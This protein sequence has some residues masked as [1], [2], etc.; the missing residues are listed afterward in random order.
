MYAVCLVVLER[1]NLVD[2][3]DP[4]FHYLT[5]LVEAQG[6]PNGQTHT[7]QLENRWNQFLDHLFFYDQVSYGYLKPKLP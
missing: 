7:L 6:Y 5:Y 2:M 4:T 1:Y 3:V